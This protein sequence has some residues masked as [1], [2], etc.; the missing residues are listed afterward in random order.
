MPVEVVVGVGAT[1]AA[2]VTECLDAIDRV[3]RPEWLLVGLSTLDRKRSLIERVAATLGVP[4][5]VWSAEGL[6]RV[7]VPNPSTLSS[8]A[9]GSASVAEAAAIL[10]SRGG[11]LVRE[12]VAAGGVTVAVACVAD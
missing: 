9:V 7:D 4:W 5:S 6:E 11:R 3:V 8:A 2:T 10:G 1:S 12:K